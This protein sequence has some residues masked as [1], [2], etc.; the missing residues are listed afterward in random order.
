MKYYRLEGRLCGDTAEGG[1]GHFS[2]SFVSKTRGRVSSFCG[3]S[4]VPTE[5]HHHL[6]LCFCGT[7]FLACVCMCVCENR[8]DTHPC[9][10]LF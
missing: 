6:K 4:S 3:F 10:V 5:V 1:I 7:K 8:T 9:F 2:V